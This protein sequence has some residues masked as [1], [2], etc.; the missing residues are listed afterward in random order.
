MTEK[1]SIKLI[2]I[3]MFFFIVL[4]GARVSHLYCLNYF[5]LCL[6]FKYA[7]DLVFWSLF[8][9]HTSARHRCVCC[10]VVTPAG[11]VLMCTVT[12][13]FSDSWCRVLCSF[14]AVTDA[15]FF[16]RQKNVC[17]H[18]FIYL[19]FTRWISSFFLSYPFT[20]LP[21]YL[22]SYL[23]VRLSTWFFF[24]S[25][26]HASFLWQIVKITTNTTSRRPD[27]LH[28]TD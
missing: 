10:A 21:S 17:F 18:L 4:I 2:L 1:G 22:C 13:P 11:S 26:K 28:E 8:I 3:T 25:S 5:P 12:L 20:Y 24:P 27:E 19:S 6:S 7:S 16:W 14:I 15:A 9:P 23:S